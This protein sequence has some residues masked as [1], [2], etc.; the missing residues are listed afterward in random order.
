MRK[1]TMRGH[2]VVAC[3]T[4]YVPSTVFHAFPFSF[5]WF[6]EQAMH[7]CVKAK[8]YNWGLCVGVALCDAGCARSRTVV[9]PTAFYISTIYH[10][11]FGFQATGK[12]VHC[13]VA[14]KRAAHDHEIENRK[15]G[16]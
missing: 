2:G 16:K 8:A 10:W 14:K 5:V 9:G 12:C 11:A 7:S 4:M 6:R 1:A 13:V 15:N 3:C